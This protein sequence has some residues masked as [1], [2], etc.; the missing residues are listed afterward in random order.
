[1]LTP[2]NMKIFEVRLDKLHEISNETGISTAELA[3]RFCISNNN[4][5]TI[6]TGIR[7]AEQASQNAAFGSAL[8]AELFEKLRNL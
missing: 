4:I 2:E 5:S 8:P 3:L 6:A 1:M 7:T